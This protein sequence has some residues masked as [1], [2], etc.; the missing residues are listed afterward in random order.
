MSLARKAIIAGAGLSGLTAA[1]A[2]QRAGHEA[3]IFEASDGVG[4]RVRT[5]IIDGYQLDRGFQVMFT[6][7]PALQQELD[8]EKLNLHAFEPGAM[9]LFG[10][11][12]HILVDPMRVPAR[13][14][15]GAF[16]SLL[17]VRDKLNTIRLTRHLSKMSVEDIFQMQDKTMSA[18]LL[19]FGFSLNY[20]E[21]FIRP[22]YGSIF[23]ERE[24]DTSVR[25]FAFVFKMLAQGQTVVPE[26][27]MGELGKQI[28][29]G[30]KPD[31]L[32]LNSPVRELQRRGERVV[33]VQLKD[34]TFHEADGVILATEADSAARLA[35]RE[36]G[37]QWRSSTELSFAM[38][39]PLHAEKLITLFA[40][41]DTLV[42]SA[43]V[44]S[45]VSPSYSPTG[46]H[47]LSATIINDY[48]SSPQLEKR[49]VD[50]FK[51]QFLETNPDSWTLLRVCKVK[52]AQFAQPVGIWS[53]ISKS[54]FAQPGLFFAGE[55]SSSSSLNGAIIAG[56]KAAKEFMEEFVPSNEVS[57]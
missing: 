55:F 4:G 49:V 13:I 20:L 48:D 1:R 40:D 16:S 9:I 51:T 43:A 22:F 39:E 14:L 56:K 5:D 29:G 19:D 44:I 35:G 15:Q 6:A 28:A 31:T 26:K 37:V 25:M 17:S 12:K 50:Y 38:P 34:G 47:L 23:L 24:L 11:K 32:R 36:F 2:L 18:Y 30:L 10:G 8:Y 52:K 21:R 57:V 45:N 27:G 54:S 42:K 41:K 53:R 7:Y 46:K 33:G 3:I